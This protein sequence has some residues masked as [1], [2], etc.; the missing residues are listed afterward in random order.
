MIIQNFVNNSLNLINPIKIGITGGIGSGKSVVSKILET[1]EIPVYNAD[2][3]ARIII[4]TN[5]KVREGL[6]NAFGEEVY[7]KETLNRALLSKIV[8]NNPE[9]LKILNSITHPVVISEGEKW[10][11]L[12]N[13]GIVAKEAAI[14]FESGSAGNL[15]VMIGVYA[16]ESIRINR[17]VN[18]DRIS[19]DEVRSRMKNQINEEIKMRLCDY[20]VIN[21]DKQLVSVQVENILKLIIEKNEH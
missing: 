3:E 16:P 7:I 2:K 19:A 5:E 12:Q 17:V 8:F 15:D 9:K 6:I 4:D 21:D 11:N 18:R 20:V 10:F 13:K 14:F 1:Y